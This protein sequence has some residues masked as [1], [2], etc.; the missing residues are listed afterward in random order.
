MSKTHLYVFR[1]CYF[2]KDCFNSTSS[3]IYSYQ[4]YVIYIEAITFDLNSRCYEYFYVC[5][6]VLLLLLLLLLLQSNFNS[7]NTD[8][9]FTMA[10]SKSFLVAM[11]SF[12]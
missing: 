3:R 12:R 11:E 4:V 10:N 6:L 1:N 9:S 5:K 2:S 8:G 7:S